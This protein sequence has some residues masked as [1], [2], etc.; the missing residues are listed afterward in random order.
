[1]KIT[2][3]LIID[4]ISIIKNQKGKP[5][6]KRSGIC[7]AFAQATKFSDIADNHPI[8]QKLERG[9]K[10]SY[11]EHGYIKFKWSLTDRGDRARIRFLKE[12]FKKLG[13]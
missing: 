6:W 3:R 12:V 7:K 13:R 2:R 1:M 9:C 5:T 8:L 10:Y 4:T 11:E